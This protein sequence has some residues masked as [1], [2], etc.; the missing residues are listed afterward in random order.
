MGKRMNNTIQLFSYLIYLI[1]QQGTAFPL[2][3]Y[4]IAK[5]GYVEQNSAKYYSLT[6]QDTLYIET[7]KTG[8]QIFLFH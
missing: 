4:V 6:E 2:F 7:E 8:N 1:V 5:N 3:S